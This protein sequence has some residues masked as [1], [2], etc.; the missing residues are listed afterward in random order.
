MQLTGNQFTTTSALL[1]NDISTYPNFPAEIR[2]PQGT[3]AGVSGF[4][5]HFGSNDI[6]TAGDDLD[7]L[8]AMNPAAMKTN[9]DDLKQNGML[10]INED[11][12]SKGQL[13]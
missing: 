1:G 11:S 8:V 9:V 4:Q 5:V 3:L 2:A 7:V 12:F 6:H 13:N 10:I